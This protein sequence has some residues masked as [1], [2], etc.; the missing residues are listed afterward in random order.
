MRRIKYRSRSNRN[1][2]FSIWSFVF[3]F[4]LIGIIAAFAF[5]I[6]YIQSAILNIIFLILG[7]TIIICMDDSGIRNWLFDSLR[8]YRRYRPAVSKYDQ[9][10][11]LYKTLTYVGLLL[12]WLFP[13]IRIVTL[14]FIILFP[15]LGVI[16]SFRYPERVCFGSKDRNELTPTAWALLIAGLFMSIWIMSNQQYNYLVWLKSGVLALFW[17]VL[18]LIFNKEYKYKFTVALGFIVCIAIFSFGTICNINRVYDLQP[19]QQYEETVIDKDMTGG[20]SRTFYIYVT[21][22]SGGN[23]SQEIEVDFRTY[24]D[25]TVGQTVTIEI[26]KGFLGFSWLDVVSDN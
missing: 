23:E 8:F 25:V 19:I 3:G 17:I 10:S 26:Y 18:F 16:R 15:L 4:M 20:K 21:P 22:W 2:P 24:K 11:E 12:T 14:V 7:F 13:R 1:L 5:S 6:W 9:Q